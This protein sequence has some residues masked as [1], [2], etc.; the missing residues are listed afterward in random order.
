MNFKLIFDFP[1]YIELAERCYKYVSFIY[2]KLSLISLIII[3]FFLC[4]SLFFTL[5][6]IQLDI[7]IYNYLFIISMIFLL[8][9]FAIFIR[10]KQRFSSKNIGILI[11]EF[12]GTTE[13][14]IVE[15]KRIAKIL[16][17]Q[18]DQ[19]IELN[20]L[21]DAKSLKIPL[22]CNNSEKAQN[23]GNLFK[24]CIVIWGSVI[25]SDNYLSI[26]PRIS[27]LRTIPFQ[28]GLVFRPDIR[29]PSNNI[30]FPP[31]SI[32]KISIFLQFL[33]ALNQIEKKKFRQAIS[34]IEKIIELLEKHVVNIEEIYFN[35]AACYLFKLDLK[36]AIVNFEKA[37]SIKPD[38]LYFRDF[39]GNS[40]FL[41]RN[42]HKPDCPEAKELLR[43]SEDN[44]REA[45]TIEPKNARL[46]Y[47]LGEVLGGQ[48]KYSEAKEKFDIAVFLSEHYRKAYYIHK[49]LGLLY[50]KQKEY[51]SA[52]TE[53]QIAKSDAPWDE[54][55]YARIGDTFFWSG[56]I[57]ESLD[58]YLK[59]LKLIFKYYKALIK[60]KKIIF[61]KW[62][63]FGLKR[64]EYW[65]GF[66][67]SP[68]L[69]SY[70]GI[71]RIRISKT[72]EVKK[73][74]SFYSSIKKAEK[75]RE[76]GLHFLENKKYKRGLKKF[77]K[78][79]KI[80]PFFIDSYFN[81]GCCYNNLERYRK[82]LFSLDIYLICNP[83]H[84]EAYVIKFI[85]LFN[86]KKDVEASM[87]MVQALEKDKAKT[88]EVFLE[89]MKEINLDKKL[90]KD[91]IQDINKIKRRMEAK[92]P[93]ALA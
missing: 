71:S 40:Y 9:L 28:H 91:I 67:A 12:D 69:I 83:E 81:L 84:I 80:S 24:A 13:E 44:W 57:K 75:Y 17:H 59:S 58:Y 82:A 93:K 22:L 39:L 64:K 35:L 48:K 31:L 87:V 86:M 50:F 8:S 41:E 77:L 89:K 46:Y 76:E 6:L 33:I 73:Y 11:F 1:K 51:K 49:N 38:N 16:E 15:G 7:L 90:A 53:Y 52:I 2:Y 70:Y 74:K 37:I 54:E 25:K 36:N 45:I 68:L 92:D 29:I 66:K 21:E 56:S 23:I 43:K 3:S 26:F 79:L 34:K 61:K 55:V 42:N 19:E 20:K 30:L 10:L 4:I 32:K 72:N 60:G 88:K 47:N 27:V 62:K 78:V 85:I 5:F 18:I 65:G 63:F 14:E